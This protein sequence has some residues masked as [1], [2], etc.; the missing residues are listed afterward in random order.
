M[1]LRGLLVAL[2][3]TATLATACSGGSADTGTVIGFTHRS[4]AGGA[5]Y[6]SLDSGA[7]AAA[8]TAGVKLLV[9]DAQNDATT[10]NANVQTFLVQGAKAVIMNPSDPQGVASSVQALKSA[11]V[12]LVV[13]NSNLSPDLQANAYCYIAED[14]KATSAKVGAE[15]ARV[16]A[17]RNAPGAA[18]KGVIIG[19]FP[20]EVVTETRKAGFLEGW[21]SVPGA[22]QLNFVADQYGHWAPDQALSA[23]REIGTANP[24]L[25][26][27]FD[28]SDLMLPGVQS[29][30]TELGMWDKLIVGTY[31]GAMSTVK[32]MVDHP[33]GPIVAT[34]A[35]FPASQGAEAVTMAMSAINGTPQ[36]E[37]CPDG[38]RY[39]DTPLYTPVNAGQYYKADQAY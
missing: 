28:E 29:A 38:V 22:P 18:V 5:W 36:A 12:P 6:E 20:S 27:V 2:A 26:V 30:L 1:R 35:N 37:A 13:V 10:Q 25:Q 3:A 24:D 9:T 14:Q 11:N 32:Q 17:A 19:G 15:L 7:Q 8:A 33:D 23:M 31:D 39:L 34:G 16:A 21:K 4:L